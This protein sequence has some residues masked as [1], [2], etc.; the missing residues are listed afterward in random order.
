MNI[1]ELLKTNTQKGLATELKVSRNT[2]RKFMFDF[3]EDHHT[4]RNRYVGLSGK[5]KELF[6]NQTKKSKVVL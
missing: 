4:V 5:K 2:I 3:N 1:P 6:I